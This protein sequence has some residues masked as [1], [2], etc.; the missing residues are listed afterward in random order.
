MG[1]VV[2]RQP[3]GLLAVFSSVTD[4]FE[5]VNATADEIADYFA[6]QARE[7]TRKDWMTACA[8]AL[9]GGTSSRM[10]GDY[11]WRGLMSIRRNVHGI[12]DDPRF[13]GSREP[14]EGA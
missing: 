13:E 14:P 1:S 2:V 7:R 5:I 9:A 10:P 8:R 11:T 6:E 12:E 3:D 4:D